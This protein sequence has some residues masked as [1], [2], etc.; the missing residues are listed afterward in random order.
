M[1]VSCQ[2]LRKKDID[3][4]SIDIIKKINNLK[5]TNYADRNYEEYKTILDKYDAYFLSLAKSITLTKNDNYNNV[6]NALKFMYLCQSNSKQKCSNML[7]SKA[8][9][10]MNMIE[11]ENINYYF[12]DLL[13]QYYSL[14]DDWIY[15]KDKNKMLTIFSEIKN[16][17]KSYLI[18]TEYLNVKRSTIATEIANKIDEMKQIDKAYLLNLL[19]QNYIL[20]GKNKLTERIAWSIFNEY[21]QEDYQHAFG[22]LIVIA[23]EFLL[24]I[25][26]NIEQKKRIYYEIDID[27][28]FRNIVKKNNVDAMLNIYFFKI[29]NI[30][31]DE[32]LIRKSI[33]P[34]FI[35]EYGSMNEV[36]TQFLKQLYDNIIKIIPE[37]EDSSS[38]SI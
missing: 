12:H 35:I 15:R 18:S 16:L 17:L 4:T 9:L 38:G 37:K 26:T 19:F 8:K 11:N 20:I 2:I 28:Y 34:N 5:I 1:N 24:K 23:R 31:V 21:I 27:D 14:Y 25:T 10:L 29:S 7:E 22:M 30:A 36:Y 6:K 32:G 13:D 33:V 3:A